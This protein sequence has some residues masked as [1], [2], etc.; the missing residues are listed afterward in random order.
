MASHSSEPSWFP[1]PPPKPLKATSATVLVFGALIGIVAV[2]AIVAV[3]A[4]GQSD[5]P[6]TPAATTTVLPAGATSPAESR[7]AAFEQ[8]MKGMDAGSAGGGVGRFRRGPSQSFR[9]AFAVCRSLL[10]TGS[11]DPVS[12]QPTGTT[13]PPVA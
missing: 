11:L 7:Q 10:Q 13:A 8:C 1:T 6:A 9:D 4:F 3:V 12:P 2:I 5:K